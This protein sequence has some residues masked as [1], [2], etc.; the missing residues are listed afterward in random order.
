MRQQCG[1]DVE[2]DTRAGKCIVLREEGLGL[3][4]DNVRTASRAVERWR[5][6]GARE[7]NEVVVVCDIRVARRQPRPMTRESTGNG[8]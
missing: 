8:G 5:G 3:R 4:G 6:S 1:Y 2:V 7:R